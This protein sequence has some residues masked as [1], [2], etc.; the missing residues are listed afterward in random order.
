MNPILL[1]KVLLILIFAIM[2]LVPIFLIMRYRR[3]NKKLSQK[4]EMELKAISRE[5]E[6][7]NS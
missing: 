3:E 6:K 4:E 7:K 2:I 1:Q 5:W